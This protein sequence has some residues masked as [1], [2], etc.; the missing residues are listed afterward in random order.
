[1]G[2]IVI[3]VIKPIINNI[4]IEG[5]YWLL[6]GGVSYTIGAV[7]YSIQ[8]INYNHAIFHVFV[9]GGSVCHF[10]TIYIYV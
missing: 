6:G 5:F 4:S 3:I 8:K 1:M 7:L 9:L 10:I 2:W